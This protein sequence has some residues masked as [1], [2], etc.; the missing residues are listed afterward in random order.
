[1]A[2]QE[3][4]PD[5]VKWGLVPYTRGMGFEVGCGPRKTFPHFISVD[6]LPNTRLYGSEVQ[7]DMVVKTVTKLDGV[8]SKSW[9]FVFAPMHPEGKEEV[10][11]QE[12][13]RVL[14]VGGHLCL[15]VQESAEEKMRALG[16]WNLMVDE[17]VEEGRFQVYR[18]TASQKFRLQCR[19]PRPAKTCAVVR[20]GAFGDLVQASSVFPGIKAQGYSITLYTAPRGYE[21]VQH[22]PHIDA[23]VVQD[24]DQVPIHE[25]GEFWKWIRTRH[26]HFVNL[27]ETVEGNLLA[28]PGRSTHEWPHALRHAFLDMNYL[29]V[30]HAVAEIPMPSRQK[31]YATEEEKAWAKRERDKMGGDKVVLWTLSGSSVHKTWP[32]LDQIVARILV[33]SPGARV[34]LAGDDSCKMLEVGWEAEPRVIKKSGEW[35]I[36]QTLAFIDQADLLVGPET[37]VMNAA[38]LHPVQKVVTL[39]HSSVENLT[40]HWKNC[41]SLTPASTKCYPCHQLHYG[42]EFCPRDEKTGTSACQ[43]DISPDAMWEAVAPLL[44]KKA[45]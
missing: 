33:S 23:F 22:D 9:D 15:Y 11:L 43:A 45:A 8:A 36:R 19:E 29:E 7:P 14:K 42:F 30:V 1:M 3:K 27:S 17:M 37:G 20:L 21:V 18:K 40:K 2:W 25:L 34:V 16:F 41:I 38:G 39:S 12:W 31:F 32:Y 5:A 26:D 4:L 13:W 35:S 6:R 24:P 28:S 10:D 44:N